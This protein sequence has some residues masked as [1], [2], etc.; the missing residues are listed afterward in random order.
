MKALDRIVRLLAQSTGKVAHTPPTLLYN[1]GWML[2]LVLDWCSEHPTA[3]EPFLF[4]P[5][6]R[7]Y[8]EALLPS[9]FG[10]RGGQREGFTHADGVIGH[11]EFRP[12]GRG[13]IELVP[14]AKQFSVIEAK[15]GSLL[16]TGIKNA[17]AYNQAARNI[18]CMAH[19]TARVSPDTSSLKRVSFTVIAP[20]QRISERAFEA[21]LALEA[22]EQAVRTRTAMFEG[23]HDEWFANNFQ[24]LLPKCE[25]KAVSWEDTV[26]TISAVDQATGKEF[27]DFLSICLKHNPMSRVLPRKPLGGSAAPAV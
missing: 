21:E 12:G 24:A 13:D 19:M 18:A 14:G 2:R 16:S 4:L 20:E 25:I 11:F 26:E 15:M 22:L 5:N 17:P 23:L 8:S 6:A 1:E 7:W 10:G 3:V 9:R 27:Q